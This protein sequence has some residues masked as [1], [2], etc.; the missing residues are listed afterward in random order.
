MLKLSNQ[1]SFSDAKTK[2]LDFE[3]F[4]L[5]CAKGIPKP[6]KTIF[7]LQRSWRRGIGIASIKDVLGLNNFINEMNGQVFPRFWDANLT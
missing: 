3:C 5:S 2:F 7:Q 6:T 1:F 4:A